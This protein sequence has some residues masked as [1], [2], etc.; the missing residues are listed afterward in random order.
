MLISS[1]S[2]QNRFSLILSLAP[3]DCSSLLPCLSLTLF[4]QSIRGVTTSMVVDLAFLLEGQ[5]PAE[6]PEQLLGAVRF[7]HLNMAAAV[8]L[9]IS[10]EV[11][12]WPLPWQ[13][14]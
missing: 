1:D 11:P 3:V 10:R 14:Q 9:D 12:Q 8:P 2:V 6:L 7:S 4:L 13:Q 5:R